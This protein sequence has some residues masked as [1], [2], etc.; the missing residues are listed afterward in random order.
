MRAVVVR[1][2]DGDP[3]AHRV[4]EREPPGLG[5]DD[6]RIAVKAASV[7]FP[8]LL[9]RSGRYQVLPAL[10]FTPGKDAAGVV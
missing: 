10:P 1:R 7:N 9:V 5:A 2:F 3:R 4:E 8:D 6:V